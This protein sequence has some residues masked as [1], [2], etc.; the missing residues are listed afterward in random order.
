[1]TQGTCAGTPEQLTIEQAD[2]RI[3][4][5]SAEGYSDWRL[6]TDAELWTLVDRQIGDQVTGKLFIDEEVFPRLARTTGGNVI[7]LA[8]RADQTGFIKCAA[9]NF[10]VPFY[11]HAYCWSDYPKLLVRGKSS[12]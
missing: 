4:D 11:S 10:V 5:Y 12:K 7:Y 9:V 6:P 2:D 8:R 3:K 1:M